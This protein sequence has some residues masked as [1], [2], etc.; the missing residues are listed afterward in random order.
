M[1]LFKGHKPR[2]NGIGPLQYLLTRTRPD[3]SYSVSILSQMQLNPTHE[4]FKYLKR[5][6]R[7]LQYTKDLGIKVDSSKELCLVGYVD[8]SFAKFPNERNGITG[9]IFYLDST[10]IVWKTCKQKIV[11]K[12]TMESELY[13][14]ESA[15]SECLWIKR[16][17]NELTFKQSIITIYCDNQATIKFIENR[18]QSSRNKHIDIRRCFVNNMLKIKKYKLNIFQQM[19]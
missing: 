5:I 2:C 18:F 4:Q 13:A 10:P 14:L 15:V 16:I 9:Y 19:I 7:Y 17:L 3:I 12:S 6:L 8:A 11:A 1:S